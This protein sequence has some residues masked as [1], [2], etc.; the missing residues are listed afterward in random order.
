MQR[1]NGAVSITNIYLSDW[2]M[3]HEIQRRALIYDT[4]YRM[5]D[6]SNINSNSNSNNNNNHINNI[7]SN[8]NIRLATTLQSTPLMKI[9][10]CNRSGSVYISSNGNYCDNL[11]P[12]ASD[13]QLVAFKASSKR[14]SKKW[15]KIRYKYREI[16]NIVEENGFKTLIAIDKL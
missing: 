9:P 15:S 1:N 3:K 16:F 11:I 5:N 7:N 14:N 12:N 2:H 13:D 8:N 6:T 10:H 4:I